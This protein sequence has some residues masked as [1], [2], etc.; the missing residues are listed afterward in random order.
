MRPT[1]SQA[2]A[3]RARGKY[4]SALKA[5][6]AYLGPQQPTPSATEQLIAGNPTASELLARGYP[7][8]VAEDVA[9]SRQEEP[10]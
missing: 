5:A 7:Q 6:T 9:R 2:I 1:R 4:Q 10:T 3:D 8:Y